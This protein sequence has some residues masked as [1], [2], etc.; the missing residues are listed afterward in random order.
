MI[1]QLWLIV[2]ILLVIISIITKQVP[3]FMV[4]LLFFLAGGI[5]RLW[6]RYSLRRVEYHRRLSSHRVFF[7]EEV[8]MEVEVSNRKPLPLPWLQV[9]D[10]IPNEVTMAK[11][12]TTPAYSM[13][14]Q[15]L[16]NLF[17]ISW[18]HKITRHY[19][20]KCPH[21]GYFIFGPTT[22]SSGDVFGFFKRYQEID[23]LDRLM[24]YPKIVPLE[25]LGIPS[26]QP[27][28]EIRTRNHLFHDPV[29]T[30]GIREYQF[31]DSM[32]SIHW[33]STARTGRLQTKIFEQ[34]TTVDMGIFL[35]V[36]TV[37]PP[38]QG[39]VSAK[40]ELAIVTAASMASNAINE[41]YRVGLY[42]NQNSPDSA[43]P[44][45]IPP[46]RHPEQLKHILE[47]LAP[48]QPFDAMP[49]ARLVVNESRNLPWGS[50]L[51]VITAAPT[52]PLLA[53]L[54]HLHR[55]GRKVVLITIGDSGSISSNG[56]T[57]YHVSDD[58]AWEKM[59]TIKLGARGY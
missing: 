6:D 8:Q 56:L 55:I 23:S 29:L 59:E 30:M 12:K 7:G 48:I 45:R 15:R 21:R 17:S 58:I 51:V 4:A 35:D 5:A 47:A 40:L 39:V 24:V 10:Q 2:S 27:L 16:T 43:E 9:E 42:V 31:G 32:K 53:A 38:Y 52:E 11:G 36:R 14:Q 54:F 41:G 19:S 44:I 13:T 46:S 3:L 50:T 25:K 28:G 18:Y 37:K 26:R 20:L 22:I 49:I 57:T 34:T 1:G 33:K